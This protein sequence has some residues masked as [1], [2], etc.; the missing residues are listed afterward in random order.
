MLTKL[1]KATVRLMMPVCPS[2]WN[3]L[4]VRNVSDKSC[5]ENQNTHFVSVTF[6]SENRTVYEIMWKTFAD[7]GKPQMT[8]WP[9][10][11]ACWF[12]TATNT[13]TQ[14]V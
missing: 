11:I 8:I 3:N 6:V 2:S 13:H 10:R 4:G 7:Q 9:M 12:T 1:Q 5:K 14:V